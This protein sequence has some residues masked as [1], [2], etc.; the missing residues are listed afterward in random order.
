ML[1]SYLKYLVIYGILSWLA[2]T[3]EVY[4]IFEPIVIRESYY[5][6]PFV[7]AGVSA[8]IP[9]ILEHRLKLL[10]EEYDRLLKQ[11]ESFP[12]KQK[13][14]LSTEKRDKLTG[15][16]NKEAFN[17]IV[18]VKIMEAKHLD[19]PLS[20][21]LFDID[22]FKKINDTYGHIVGDKVLKEVADVVR[23][24]IR[25][26]EYFVRWGGE[27]FIILLPG[28]GLEGAR[29]VAE[30]L[31]RVIEH[32]RFPDVERVTCSFGVTQLLRDDTISSFLERAD[33]ALY[34]SKREGR[35]RV[36]VIL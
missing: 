21:I 8:L 2:F 14:R 12:G 11:R 24:N 34:Q 17:E 10:Q 20:M 25:K 19:Q 33:E 3:A 16:L 28:T 30:K 29:M 7:L 23:E 27:E 26:S 31:R 15:A 5:I 18:G 4:I 13:I 1:W 6:I 9:T 32:H 22:F 36:S 35:N